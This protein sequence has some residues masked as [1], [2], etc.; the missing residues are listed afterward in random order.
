MWI[1]ANQYEGIQAEKSYEEICQ[2]HYKK[3][4]LSIVNQGNH[5][6]IKNQNQKYN[7]KSKIYYLIL[8]ENHQFNYHYHHLIIIR[9]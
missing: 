6:E 2:I 1:E 9:I 4:I 5:K 3:F 7:K 8:N